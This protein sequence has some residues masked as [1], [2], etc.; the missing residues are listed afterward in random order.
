MVKRKKHRHTVRASL[1]VAA[2]MRAGNSLNL[3]IYHDQEKIGTL[4]IGRGS[5]TWFGRKRRTG[6][7]ISWDAFA[8]KMDELTY[9]T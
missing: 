9:E 2:L 1:Q 6:K 4:V 7:R 3:A 5:I 8:Q